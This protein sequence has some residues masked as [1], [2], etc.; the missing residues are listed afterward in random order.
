MVVLSQNKA[1]YEGSADS[2]E[3][4]ELTRT[5]FATPIHRVQGSPDERTG[6]HLGRARSDFSDFELSH[7]W[8]LDTVGFPSR[9]LGRL[10]HRAVR[11]SHP[12]IAPVS[13][14]TSCFVYLCRFW[15][16]YMPVYEYRSGSP[17]VVPPSGLL[18]HVISSWLSPF[19]LFSLQGFDPAKDQAK[20]DQPSPSST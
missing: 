11:D 18:I 17:L 4:P 20:G 6:L 12:G 1:P 9:Y 15:G 16:A 5:G 13:L 19:P 8:A 10:R 14:S 7:P 3:T 2:I